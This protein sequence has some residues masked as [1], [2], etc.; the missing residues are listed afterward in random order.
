MFLQIYSFVDDRFQDNQNWEFH[1]TR[2]VTRM[3]RLDIDYARVTRH[4]EEGFFIEHF[5]IKTECFEERYGNS[6]LPWIS[7][8]K[9]CYFSVERSLYYL[10]RQYQIMY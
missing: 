1:L 2:L 3:T 7:V 5:S 10:T 6:L 4:E 9:M 8:F